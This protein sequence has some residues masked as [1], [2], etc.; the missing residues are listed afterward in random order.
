[1]SKLKATVSC[2]G[3]LLMPLKVAHVSETDLARL[4]SVFGVRKVC[5]VS[6]QMLG[7]SPG[8]KNFKFLVADATGQWLRASSLRA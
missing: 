1:M 7:K 4:A 3:T 2:C 6:I 8:I 5:K